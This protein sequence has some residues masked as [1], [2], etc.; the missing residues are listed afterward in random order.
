[1]IHFKCYC[2]GSVLESPESQAGESEVCPA[3]KTPNRVPKPAPEP[4]PQSG[5]G[6]TLPD[7]LASSVNVASVPR[8]ANL[9][10][11]AARTKRRRWPLFLAVAGMALIVAGAGGF[12]LYHTYG[13][14]KL[15][16]P[17]SGKSALAALK[18]LQAKTEVGITRADYSRE[19]GDM[20]FTVKSFL[21]SGDAKKCPDFARCVWLAADAFR[22]AS[23]A[24]S[25][26]TILPDL[27]DLQVQQA[28]RLA[29]IS[30]HHAEGILFL[31][32][33]V[34]RAELDK[35]RAQIDELAKE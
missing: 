3:C 32:V 33:E 30:I 23:R 31:G 18:K 16:I 12:F 4:I 34:Q 2:C 14:K 29:A 20:W 26:P 7:A 10:P 21:E 28:W 22:A 35:L 17:A 15:R 19:C 25:Q 6:H 13:P 27:A 24:W 9:A 5:R 1:M 11:A 8:P